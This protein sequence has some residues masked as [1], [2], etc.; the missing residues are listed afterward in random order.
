M[1]PARVVLAFVLAAASAPAQAWDDLGHMTVAAIAYERLTPTAHR[2][3]TSLLKLNP[4]YPEWIAVANGR[5]EDRVAFL[6]AAAWPDFIKHS[7]GFQDDGEIPL[8]PDAARN[9]GYTDKLMHKYWHYVDIPFSPDGTPLAATRIP[10]AQTQIRVFRQA[11]AT[12]RGDADAALQSYDLVWLLHLVGDVHQPLHATSRFDRKHPD[13][14]AGGNH[15]RVCAANCGSLHG[16]WDSLLEPASGH[17]EATCKAQSWAINEPQCAAMKVAAALAGAKAA[18]PADR[19]LA[20]D[21]DEAHWIAESLSLAKTQAYAAPVGLGKGPY[22]LDAAYEH[23]ARNTAA[24]RVALAGAR[25]A[26][27][28]NL[29]FK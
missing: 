6:M 21:T 5:D 22:D 7:A 11:L 15:V 25:L 26:N 23:A 18:T 2:R 14:D 1:T 20:A 28:L 16:Y 12:Q 9:I 10:N 4:Q 19:R 29:A 24:A 3:A 13:G 17:I 8:G 27:L